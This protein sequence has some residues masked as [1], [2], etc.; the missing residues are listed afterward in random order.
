[1]LTIGHVLYTNCK[2][3]L[4]CN[5]NTEKAGDLYHM[6]VEQRGI[7]S[8]DTL[9]KALRHP[10]LGQNGIASDIERRKK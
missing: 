1:M 2:L 7:P 8:W 4:E 3:I 5:H 9:A 6:Q 10:R